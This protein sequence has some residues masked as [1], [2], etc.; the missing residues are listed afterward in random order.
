MAA[1]VKTA[2][3][4]ILLSLLPGT[5]GHG[6]VKRQEE[7]NGQGPEAREVT[8]GSGVYAYT[9]GGAYISMFIITTDGLMV[10]DPMNKGHS[11]QMLVE[12]RKITNAPIKYLFYSH[13]HYDH[14]KGGQVF[15]DEGATIVAHIDAYDYIKDNPSEDLVLPDMK[16]TGD[17]FDLTLGDTQIEL[18]HAGVSHGNGMTTFVLPKEKV[19]KLRSAQSN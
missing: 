4:V 13:N 11:E 19:S 14:A 16:W 7:G 12:I 5:L 3:S 8:P 6:I 15:K 17:R 18:H 2:V 1:T 10:I 9:T